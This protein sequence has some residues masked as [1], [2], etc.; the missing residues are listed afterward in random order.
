M[1]MSN[2]IKDGKKI[3]GTALYEPEFHTFAK[4]GLMSFMR[5]HNVYGVDS[6]LYLFYNED[7]EKNVKY[8]GEK[9]VKGKKVGA[10]DGG[11]NWKMFFVHLTA[12]GLADGEPCKFDH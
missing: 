6:Y 8:H 10:A 9:Y 4:D 7:E 3:S 12:L 2:T 11:A 1:F 5:Y